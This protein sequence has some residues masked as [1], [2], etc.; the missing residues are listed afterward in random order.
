MEDNKLTGPGEQPD[1]QK[2]GETVSIGVSGYKISNGYVIDDY[3]RE[4]NGDAG[5]RKFREMQIGDP[6][7]GAL[8]TAI[9]MMLR[10][11]EFKF[12][13]AEA[14]MD[15]RYLEFAE[16]QFD[17]LEVTWDEILTEILSFLPFGFCLMEMV[18][19]RRDDGLIT[20]ANMAPRAQETIWEWEINEHGDILGVWQWPPLGGNRIFI[21]YTHLL[22]FRTKL[23]RGNPEGISILRNAY[24]SYY[25]TKQLKMVEAQAIERELN[26]LPVVRIPAEAMANT[27][28]RSAYEKIARDVK[29]NEQGGLVIPS[30]PY[31][32][33]EGKPTSIRQY[34]VELLSSNGSRNIDTD[35]IIRR[36]QQDMVRTVLADF[37]M[38]G[39]GDKGSF[40]L[41]KSKT[42]LF[43]RSIEGY[44]NIITAQLNTKWM[45]TLWDL[46]GFDMEMKPLLVTGNVT[47]VDLEELGKYVRDTGLIAALDPNTENYLK[48][49]AGLPVK[50]ES[51]ELGG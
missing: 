44:L 39:S 23:N 35:T 26:G 25:Y 43:L 37:L 28:V 31:K 48:E 49:V 1:S 4:L 7:V 3:Q 15:N 38:L 2:P 46:N 18:Y 50:E 45:N 47:P 36:H 13:P 16:S 29:L 51:E 24:T 17:D 27:T 14:D 6:T 40:A 32:D 8:L 30:N 12:E 11:V 20:T 22:H 42:D 21:P 34:D 9:E 33:N 41:S 10:A 19:K 5:R